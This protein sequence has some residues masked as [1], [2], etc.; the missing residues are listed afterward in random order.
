LKSIEQQYQ[1]VWN[2]N[3]MGDYVWGLIRQSDVNNNK[4][5]IR[6]SNYF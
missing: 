3:M 1:G 2:D 5:Q 6:R 4:K